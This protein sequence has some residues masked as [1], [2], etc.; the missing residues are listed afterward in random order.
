MV[1][2]IE[3]E[4]DGTLRA[5]ART[6]GRNSLWLI[7]RSGRSCTDVMTLESSGERVLPV[8]SFEEEGVSY[9]GI[10]DGWR[11]KEVGAGELVSLLYG[12]CRNV[13]RV[14]LDPAPESR[15]QW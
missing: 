14:I 12:P 7:V 6:P 3:P 13:K 2:N 4:M 8:F 10:R 11:I 1:L 9:V 5:Q 15:P